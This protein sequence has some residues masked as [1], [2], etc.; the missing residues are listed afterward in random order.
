MSRDCQWYGVEQH[1]IP[2]DSSHGGEG[3][4]PG[5]GKERCCF[6]S[7]SK[8]SVKCAV[9]A[10]VSMNKAAQRFR[11]TGGSLRQV[12]GQTGNY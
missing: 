10:R 12:L 9:K 6:H 8:K 5:H 7:E 2:A 3:G 1:H 4:S 11:R